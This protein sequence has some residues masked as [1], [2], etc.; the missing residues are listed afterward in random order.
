MVSIKPRSA[1]GALAIL[2][3]ASLVVCALRNADSAVLK[4]NL[5]NPAPEHDRWRLPA[6]VR[7]WCWYGTHA[8]QE[9]EMDLSGHASGHMNR[10]AQIAYMQAFANDLGEDRA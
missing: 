3:P 6:K 5:T 4:Q 2:L 7:P 1:S 8:Q 9:R 10:D